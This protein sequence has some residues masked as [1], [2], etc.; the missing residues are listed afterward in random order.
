MLGVLATLKQDGLALAY[1]T[2]D[3]QGDED[4]VEAPF[5]A[6]YTLC[7]QAAVGEN[8]LALQYASDRWRC[9]KVRMNVER[10]ARKLGSSRTL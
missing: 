10:N 3:L 8:P 5:Q 6:C 1:A 2:H 7:L 4:V 9:D